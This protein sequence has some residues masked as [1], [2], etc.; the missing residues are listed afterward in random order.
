MYTIFPA[1][2]NREIGPQILVFHRVGLAVQDPRV[3]CRKMMDNLK[4]VLRTLSLFSKG[5]S[6]ADS[7]YLS[8]SKGTSGADLCAFRAHK[9]VWAACTPYS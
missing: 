2:K 9:R 1:A 3:Q 5:T 4:I 8:F 7:L 6:G